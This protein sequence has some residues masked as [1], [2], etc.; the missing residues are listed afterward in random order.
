MTSELFY[1]RVPGVN[2]SGT[3]YTIKLINNLKPSNTVFKNSFSVAYPNNKP[4]NLNTHEYGYNHWYFDP[5]FRDGNEGQEYKYM[6]LHRM[7]VDGTYPETNLTN[8]TLQVTSTTNEK[9]TP[10]QMLLYVGDAFAYSAKPQTVSRGLVQFNFDLATATNPST[11]QAEVAKFLTTGDK[12]GVRNFTLQPRYSGKPD[13]FGTDSIVV[14]TGPEYYS[15]GNSNDFQ[16]IFASDLSIAKSQTIEDITIRPGDKK[17][18]YEYKIGGFANK[19]LRFNKSERN[20]DINLVIDGKIDAAKNSLNQYMIYREID[21]AGNP[22]DDW[23]SVGVGFKN[24]ISVTGDSTDSSKLPIISGA[25]LY[26]WDYTRVY[27][28]YN[29]QYVAKFYNN[30]LLQLFSSYDGSNGP[31]IAVSGIQFGDAPKRKMGSVQLNTMFAGDIVTQDTWNNN[32]KNKKFDE[33]IVSIITADQN[34][35]GLYDWNN[36]LTKNKVLF[37]DNQLVAWWGQSDGLESHSPKLTQNNNFYL[38]GDD[39]IKVNSRNGQYLENT[40]H[41]GPYGSAA[42]ISS[43]GLSNGPVSNNLIEPYIHRTI[44]YSN[45]YDDFGGT[46]ANRTYFSNAMVDPD[47]KLPSGIS[48]NTIESL[49][50]PKMDDGDYVGNSYFRQGII[51]ATQDQY[52]LYSGAGNSGRVDNN[53]T[54]NAG[55]YTFNNYQNYMA[56]YLYELADAGLNVDPS[57]KVAFYPNYNRWNDG[58]S[59]TANMETYEN[60]SADKMLLESKMLMFKVDNNGNIVPLN[61][62]GTKTQSRQSVN[63]FGITVNRKF[64]DNA[65]GLEKVTDDVFMQNARNTTNNARN[66]TNKI[67]SDV[68]TGMT[69]TFNESLSAP[70][71]GG[72]IGNFKAN[73]KIASRYSDDLKTNFVGKDSENDSIINGGRGYSVLAPE[74]DVRAADV[75]E[76][77]D[78]LRSSYSRARDA[79][80]VENLGNLALDAGDISGSQYLPMMGQLLER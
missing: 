29:D 70:F 49:Y 56:D 39:V 6:E 9:N 55:G 44:Q 16:K 40:I 25:N 65:F 45:G 62:P 66:A 51:D 68:L 53:R 22:K 46:I 10:D 31:S 75:F 4:T 34:K 42:N 63:V 27:P 38:V 36:G 30:V 14:S 71:L 20:K 57:F 58:V 41:S 69:E 15:P 48:R 1:G 28:D 18:S 72:S 26:P 5:L 64:G 2:N 35:E 8:F 21:K 23:N 33:R 13:L 73:H 32:G 67:P 11:G 19:I 80:L 60:N 7:R 52:T 37:R 74:R 78:S 59:F 24:K 47:G 12:K 54:Y 77:E 17:R 3:R 79:V 43:F 76:P 50:I 61:I